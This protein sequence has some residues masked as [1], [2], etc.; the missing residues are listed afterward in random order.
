MILIIK[1]PLVIV[2][3]KLKSPKERQWKYS[4]NWIQKTILRWTT[5]YVA[6]WLPAKIGTT[7]N[8][9]LFAWDSIR[10]PMSWY[11]LPGWQQSIPMF[12][13]SSVTA[14]SFCAFSSISP[15]GYVFEQSPW[16]PSWNIHVR[17]ECKWNSYVS[18]MISRNFC[19]DLT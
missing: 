9:F 13:H 1:C 17:Y 11:G 18:A 8:P 7:S 6:V 3:L 10:K 2:K 16:N 15:T 14:M 12:K 5:L 19:N 4:K